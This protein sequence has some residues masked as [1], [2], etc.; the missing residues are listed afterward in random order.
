MPFGEFIDSFGALS[1]S[2]CDIRDLPPPSDLFD[3]AFMVSTSEHFDDP[4]GSFAMISALLAPGS[5]I[6]INHHNYYGWNGH[7]RAPWR[8]QDVN[9]RI[10]RTEPSSIGGMF[11]I[12]CATRTVRI[13][14]TTLEFTS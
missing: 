1:L 10:R 14:S 11:G 5:E 2:D 3:A 4:R 6:F 9:P 8:V 13:T 12:R 7:H